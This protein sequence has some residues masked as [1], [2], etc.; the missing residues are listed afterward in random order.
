MKHH[1]CSATLLLILGAL[2]GTA[3]AIAASAD[4]DL[5]HSTTFAAPADFT[6][7]FETTTPAQ[8]V[9]EMKHDQHSDGHGIRKTGPGLQSSLLSRPA[10]TVSIE[11]ASITARFRFAT[12]LKGPSFGFWARVDTH[13]TT[14]YLG[15][16]SF[17]DPQNVRLRIFDSDSNPGKQSAGT[18]LKDEHIKITTALS[19]KVFYRGAFRVIT[20]PA[21]EASLSLQLS[22]DDGTPLTNTLATDTTNP[23]LASG[24]TG[25]RIAGQ[26]IVWDDFTLSRVK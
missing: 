3:A 1:L 6:D 12:L 14:G 23:R 10:K 4:N 17:D 26:T 21:G 2:T 25:V 9:S 13:T 15:I 18:L 24:R 5:I 19:T 16:I 20:T 8:G 11:N 22:A 7:N